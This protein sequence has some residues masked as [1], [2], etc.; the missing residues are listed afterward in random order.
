MK[1][2]LVVALILVMVCLFSTNAQEEFIG[3]KHGISLSLSR[4][5]EPQEP[6]GGIG[7]HS[8]KGFLVGTS[9]GKESFGA[10]TGLMV[11]TLAESNFPT[12]PFI[13]LSYNKQA[14]LKLLNFNFGISQVFFN[15]SNFPFSLGA[16]FFLYKATGPKDH[17]GNSVTIIDNGY[18][19]TYTQSLFTRNSVSPFVAVSYTNTGEED[20][21]GIHVG[22]NIRL[23]DNE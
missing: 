18:S 15:Y 11:E 16:T 23:S 8:K 4:T 6:I 2:K 10:Y 1:L 12:K 19:A 3:K 13:A 14:E 17:F 22:I 7:F 5:F 20:T 21:K 9:F